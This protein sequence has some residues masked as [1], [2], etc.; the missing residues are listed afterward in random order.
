MT[1][2]PEQPSQDPN[3]NDPKTV[4]AL[5]LITLLG[6]F[7]RLVHVVGLDFPLNDG[8][9]FY[10][11]ILDLQHA[12][13]ILPEFASYNS[14]AI[15]FAYPPLA[16]Y[17][18]AALSDGFGWPVLSIVRLLP[19]VISI[20]TIPAFIL[21]CRRITPSSAQVI[22]ATFAFAFLPT[23]FDWLIV[24]GGLTR[25]FGY[26][27]AI[28]T[29]WQVQALFR[30]GGR[31]PVLLTILFA[32]LTILS[33]PGTAWFAVYS[34][35]VILAFNI[36]RDPKWW[37]KSVLVGLGVTILTSPWWLTV[38]SRHGLGVL[39]APFQTE[40]ASIVSFLTPFTFLFTNEPLL[41][42]LAFCGLLGVFTSLVNRA[43][44]YP[45]WLFSVFL[46][47]SRLGATYS[48]VPVALLAGIGIDRGI[49]PLFSAK[50]KGDTGRGPQLLPKIALAYF[51]L[52]AL[53]NA[54]LGIDYQTVTQEQI[55]AMVWIEAN[56]PA[57]SQFL[58][59]TGTPEYGI[60]QVSEWFPVLSGRTSLTTPQAH[61]WLPNQEFNRRDQIHEELQVCAN[62]D[63]VC[64]ESWA[65]RNDISFTHLYIP[66]S[67]D[68][69]FS[70]E[71]HTGYQVLYDG[72]G[73][74]VLSQDAA[75]P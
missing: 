52:Y 26:L 58:V 56:T 39:T 60:D 72:T 31:R 17:I 73:G 19:A 30:F 46:F 29:L 75:L 18:A 53:I 22:F 9:F 5:V 24:G 27:F 70:I 32:S 15:P 74:V 1:G 38:V 47:E 44:F 7:I 14:R 43:Y 40:G 4:L 65:N 64:I 37:S 61:E 21:L 11:A 62:Q 51:G 3:N 63:L 10:Q 33:H 2:N 12:R 68:T 57:D 55:A 59:L 66:A 49:R 41:D 42:V 6:G 48:V 71:P 8:G 23:S 25:S 67:A 50:E 16:F 69:I 36:K 34:T 13:Y 35:A 28:L 54:Y 20:L 45:V